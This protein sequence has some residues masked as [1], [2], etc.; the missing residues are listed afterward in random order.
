MG[1]LRRIAERFDPEQRSQDP[2]WDALQADH[3]LNRVA[4]RNAENLSTVLA[5]VQAVSGSIASLPVYVYQRGENGREVDEHHPLMR[6]S[7]AG[8]NP[9]QSWPDFIEWLMSSVLLRGN[10]LAQ[11]V[12]DNSGIVQALWPIPWENAS[13]LLLPNRRLA[14]DI[15]DEHGHRRLLQDE[16][17]HVTDRT[18]DGIIGRSR[19]QRAR[20]VVSTG[21]QVQEYAEAMF[22][23][24]ATP[25][26]IIE[27]DGKI[28][29]DAM[30]K[31]RKQFA[32]AYSGAKNARRAMILDQ[33][34][35]FK[36]VSISPE[37]AE[38]L[39]SRRFTVEEIS[40]IYS[41][42]P[43]IIG[44]LTHGTFTNAETAGRWFAQHTLT[45]WLRKL[46]AAVMRSLFSEAGRAGREF[47][48]D[49]SGFLRGDPEQRWNSHKIAVQSGILTPNEVRKVEGYSP[50]ADGDQLDKSHDRSY[51]AAPD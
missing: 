11:I 30:D 45:P 6:L 35:H 24:Q 26:G 5:C 1:L 9:R 50:H 19:L 3:G 20:S 46:E 40:R 8:A 44:D 39:A 15:Q 31:L 12:T 36:P 25:S 22:G 17:L 48:F 34:L 28:D 27:A 41:V 51:T 23:N 7:Q 42:P 2:S 33:G 47:H 10:G 38:L 49:L 21:L 29:G 37:D 16:V 43:P 4:A 14:F 32:S 13:V 18:D